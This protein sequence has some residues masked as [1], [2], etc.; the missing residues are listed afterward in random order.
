MPNKLFIMFLYGCIPQAKQQNKI[1]HQSSDCQQAFWYL[2]NVDLL[3]ITNKI[4][5]INSLS[6]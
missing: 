3:C 6:N 4:I 1:K 2:I 5:W